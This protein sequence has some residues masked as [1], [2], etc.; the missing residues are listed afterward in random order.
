[1]PAAGCV[2]RHYCASEPG[3]PAEVQCHKRDGN[4]DAEQDT[5]SSCENSGSVYALILV[6]RSD[7]T[8]GN[9]P[10]GALNTHTHTHTNLAAVGA[11]AKNTSPRRASLPALEATTEK[12]PPPRSVG[13]T[14]KHPFPGWPDAPGP[15]LSIAGSP[16]QPG[17]FHKVHYFRNDTR[18]LHICPTCKFERLAA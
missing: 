12:V 4:L 7:P 11:E 3:T 6:L 15:L 14:R 18:A 1:M 5:E 10:W 13:R 16:E 17:N 2:A 9:Q 8:T